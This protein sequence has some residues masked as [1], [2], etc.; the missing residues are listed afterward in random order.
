MLLEIFLSEV[1]P[2]PTLLFK[3]CGPNPLNVAFTARTDVLYETDT[4]VILRSPCKHNLTFM[5]SKGVD[6][7][8]L[9]KK[10]QKNYTS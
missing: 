4:D 6:A 10:I 3:C 2:L 8:Q 5:L 7:F 9:K 1:K